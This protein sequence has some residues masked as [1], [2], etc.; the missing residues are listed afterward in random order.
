MPTTIARRFLS[1]LEP[2]VSMVFFSAE[3]F[4][5]YAKIGLVD[6]WAA[7]FCS[8]AAAMGPVPADVV[9]ATFYN[10]NPEL[11][12]RSVDWKVASPVAV[13]DARRRGARRALERLLARDDGSTPDLS[14]AAELLREAVAACPPQGRPLAAAHAALP[15][16]DDPLLATWHG[17]MVLR[18]F[19]GDGHVAV[20]LTHAVEPVEAIHLHA[21]YLGMT[22][23][24][25]EAFFMTR[26]W[27]VAVMEE[28]AARLRERGFLDSEGAL[29]DGGAKFRMMLEHDTDRLAVA[30]FAALGPDR[31]AE[32]LEI[33]EPHARTILDRKGVP[34]PLRNMDPAHPLI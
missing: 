25:R 24:R 29:T 9:V 2:I 23:R 8:R 28:A 12:R 16:P 19:R 13:Q 34:S 27:D 17:A 31:C 26:Q 30:P 14:R 20:L 11:V 21:G 22:G 15:W 3:P 33:L 10:F 18:E 7:Y 6:P 32:L 4:E 5:E 1:V